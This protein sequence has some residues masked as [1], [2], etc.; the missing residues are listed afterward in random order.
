MTITA[1]GPKIT[2]ALNGTEVTAINLDDWMT[3][4]KRPD[5]SDHKFSHVAIG[6]LP[7]TGYFGFQDHGSDCWFKNVKVKEL[8]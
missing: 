3:P 5:G 4:G 1:R 8:D 2:V 6:K 7:R